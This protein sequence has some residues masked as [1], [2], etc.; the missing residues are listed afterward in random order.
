MICSLT[1]LNFRAVFI[2]DQRFLALKQPDKFWTLQIKY[3]QGRDAG[4]YECQVS[5]EPKVSARVHLQVV[6]KFILLANTIRHI[7]TTQLTLIFK[8]YFISYLFHVIYFSYRR[9]I[10]WQKKKK[11]ISCYILFSRNFGIEI[12]FVTHA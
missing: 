4:A 6:G 7:Y 8:K 1:F 12:T 2:A 5:T 3:V 9:I 11:K 10:N